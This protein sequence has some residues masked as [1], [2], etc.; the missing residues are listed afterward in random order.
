MKLVRSKEK[1]TQDGIGRSLGYAF[2]EFKTHHCAVTTLRVLNNNPE[3]FGLDK[4]K[5]TLLLSL[6]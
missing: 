4:V 2:V 5:F 3:I 1:F 6:L